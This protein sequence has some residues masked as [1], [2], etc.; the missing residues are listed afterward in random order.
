MKSSITLL[1]SLALGA[2]ASNSWAGTSNYFLQGM[3]LS[4]QQAYLQQVANDGG[5]VVRLWVSNQSG[6]GSCVKGSVS[7]IGV[8]ELETTLGQYNHETMD[9]LDQ[10]LV[11]I[12]QYGLKAIISPHDGNKLN[13][14]NGND[15]YG[16]TYGAGNFYSEQAAFNAYDARLKYILNYKGAHSGKVWKNWDT[17]IMAFDLQ[18]EPFASDPSKC[19]YSNT[20]AWACGR[21]ATLRSILG[22]NNRIKIASGGLGGD[23]SHGCTFMSSAMTCPQLDIVSVHRYA[24]PE[25]SNPNQWANSYKSWRSQANGKLVQL[26]EWGVD[27]TKYNAK[28]EFPA[29]TKDMNSAG[30]P[31]LYWMYLP[32]K[33]CNVQDTD[34]F[35]FYIDSGV[36]IAEQMKA[37]NSASCPQDWS[38]IVW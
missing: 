35:P 38:E 5:K 23:I 29:N 34:Q 24:G 32:T 11:Y 1:T 19:T 3:A 10:T 25:G 8:P 21:A 9:A 31:W 6:G 4:E 18:N 7:S 30:L 2:S 22:A 13:G 17:A 20:Q 14:P 26:E 28:T 36:P 37:A 27:T 12:E 16:K 15:I 33:K